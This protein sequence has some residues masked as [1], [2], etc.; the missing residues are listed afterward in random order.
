MDV[1]K[2]VKHKKPSLPSSKCQIQ[3]PKTLTA[4]FE[5]VI[6]LTLIFMGKSQIPN[7]AALHVYLPNV[8]SYDSYHL[9]ILSTLQENS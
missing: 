9:L 1:S 7:R 3:N 5:K 2:F 8:T 4:I 6:K